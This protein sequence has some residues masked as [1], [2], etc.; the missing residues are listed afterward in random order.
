MIVLTRRALG[1]LAAA[2]GLTPALP[3]ALPAMPA[4]LAVGLQLYT[5]GED[6]ERDVAGTLARIAA[7]GY[8]DVETAGFAG[9]SA[10]AMAAALRKAGLSCRSAHVD[11]ASLRGDLPARMADAKT[12]GARYLV[13][14]FP[15]LRP[16]R[17]G[18]VVK[19]MALDD[20]RW[21]ADEL[22]RIGGDVAKQGLTLAYHNHNLEFRRFGN[23]VAY[24]E[25]LRLTDPDLVKQEMDVG[26][27][28]AAGADP[29]AYLAAHPG[30]FRLL[31]LK[32]VQP[33]GTPNAD[34]QIRTTEVGSGIIDWKR[35]LAAARAAGTELAYVEQ[36]P[37]FARP[38]LE[39]AAM[40]WRYLDGL[41]L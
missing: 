21:L 3:R 34:M 4:G 13:V 33:G 2:L 18:D 39:A 16:G 15:M 6:L 10:G 31:H 1:R 5:V 32:D 26:W 17:S 30:R 19:E 25:L 23:V 14:P 29:L 38:R 40:S 27:V 37:P 36:E 8:R 24:D 11:I 9:K 7:I 20:W 28:T 22:N 12:I 41:S 35:L